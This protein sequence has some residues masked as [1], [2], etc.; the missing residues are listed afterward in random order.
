MNDTRFRR[1]ALAAFAGWAATVAVVF[2]LPRDPATFAV[3]ALNALAAGAGAW[4]C[5]H[6]ATLEPPAARGWRAVAAGLAIL[7]GYQVYP[8]AAQVMLGGLPPFP[9]LVDWVS[10]GDIPLYGLGL[11]LWPIA[12]R[13]RLE[14][15][16]TAL[17]GIAFSASIFFI[18]WIAGL[19]DVVTASELDTPSRVLAAMQFVGSALA[20]GIVVYL[21]APR[22]A[23]LLG[24]VGWVATGMLVETG[25]NL[26][27]AA[28]S[29]Q[30]RYYL[31]HPLDLL[32]LAG[33]LCF[34][35]APLSPQPVR[36]PVWHEPDPPGRR[37]SL[38]VPYLPAGLALA[39]AMWRLGRPG[40][41]G[42]LILG[43]T[44]LGLSATVLL[45]Q[46]LA[47]RDIER[48][49]RRLEDQVTARTHQL[50]VSQAALAQSERMEAV[51]RMAGGIAHDFNNLVHAITAWADVLGQ[52]VNRESPAGLAVRRILDIGSRAHAIVRRLLTF[53]RR[54]PV[55][56][57]TVDLGQILHASAPLLHQLAGAGIHLM[58]RPSA[59]PVFLDPAQLEQLLSTLTTRARELMPGGGSL[60]FE[61]ETVN[62]APGPEGTGGGPHVRLVVTD[63]APAMNA[64]ARRA[65][66]DAFTGVDDGASALALATCE[67]IA[68][69]A[70]GRIAVTSATDAGNTIVVDLPRAAP[71]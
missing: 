18:V 55:A 42:D 68:S 44:G 51:G 58:L 67:A 33:L 7:C 64:E 54:Q 57:Q 69:Q 5:L 13:Q 15:V 37:A 19:G 41:P 62:L 27:V 46:Y 66:F 52:S 25:F 48:L 31:G 36:D 63:T 22:P 3:N 29:L 40:M 47:L 32:L 60:T 49:S 59:G 35:L 28:M 61:V 70:G 1:I 9:S 43:W 12:P 45:R 71:A 14:R 20:L 50:A 6:R 16:R 2:A 10:V 17:D 4:T 65:A 53:A 30:G 38:W 56:P 21:T 26:P 34:A 39:A 8:V 23:R 11:L 24:P